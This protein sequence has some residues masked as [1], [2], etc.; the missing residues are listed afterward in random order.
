MSAPRPTSTAVHLTPP[1]MRRIEAAGWRPG[2]IALGEWL[3]QRVEADRAA[4]CSCGPLRDEIAVPGDNLR[5]PRYGCK[6]CNKWDG[7]VRFWG[8]ESV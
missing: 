3:T 8:R 5:I 1:Q 7:P 2:T 6:R 4:P